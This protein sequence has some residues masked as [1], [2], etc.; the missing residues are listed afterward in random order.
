MTDQ[1][2]SENISRVEEL[3]PDDFD[4]YEPDCY[5]CDGSG[6]I[7]ICPDDMCRGAGECIHG[8][9]EILCPSC[10]GDL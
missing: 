4:D 5:R 8:D 3:H 6:T 9:G 7:L 2:H 1:K 10:N